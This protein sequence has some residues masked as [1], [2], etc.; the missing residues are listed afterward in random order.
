MERMVGRNGFAL[1]PPS[2]NRDPPQQKKCR[3][4]CAWGRRGLCTRGKGDINQRQNEQTQS[5][6]HT[7]CKPTQ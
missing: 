3:Y 4:V 2:V 1:P 6:S 7:E 5:H